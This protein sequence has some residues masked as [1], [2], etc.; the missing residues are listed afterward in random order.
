[1]R[2]R[3]EPPRTTERWA[4]PRRETWVPQ[5]SDGPVSVPAVPVIGATVLS[6]TAERVDRRRHKS[7][8]VLFWVLFF[9]LAASVLAIA[10]VRRSGTSRTA[11]AA[12]ESG[13]QAQYLAE[14][15]A[16]HAL[17]RLVGE[18]GFP[19]A[20]TATRSAGTPLPPSPPWPRSALLARAWPIRVTCF[21]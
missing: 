18:A 1:M 7:G 16:N 6:A 2:M 4:L 10:F 8:L 20:V 3:E 5:H 21:G 9:V 14:S 13:M 12:R 17:W 15:A 11:V 19:A